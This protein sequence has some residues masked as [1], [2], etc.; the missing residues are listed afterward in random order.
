[1]YFVRDLTDRAGFYSQAVDLFEPSEGQYL[2]NEMQCIFGQSDPHQMLADD[3]PGR[4]VFRDSRWSFEEG[5][6]NT[7]ESYDLR[8]N[9]IIEQLN[10]S[11]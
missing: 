6:F 2:V 5:N 1:L 9:W 8:V 4:Y 3:R 7:N 10:H 11:K